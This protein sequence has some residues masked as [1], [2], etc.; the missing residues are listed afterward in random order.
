MLLLD[1]DQIRRPRLAWKNEL[2]ERIPISLCHERPVAIYK[3]RFPDLSIR[4]VLHRTIEPCYE[5]LVRGPRAVVG[6]TVIP[7]P[8]DY[9]SGGR[10]VGI[11]CLEIIVKGR[12]FKDDSEY[13]WR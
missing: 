4:R 7:V 5:P 2:V 10:W 1:S 6:R 8:R 3:I 9:G 11:V 13:I 12:E